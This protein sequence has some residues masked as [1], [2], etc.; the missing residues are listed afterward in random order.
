MDVPP[1]G[2]AATRENSRI[3]TRQRARICAERASA[4]SNIHSA[5]SFVSVSPS[6][7]P[8]EFAD[9]TLGRKVA[10]SRKRVWKIESNNACF[11]NHPHL[12]PSGGEILVSSLRRRCQSEQGQG[13]ETTIDPAI[14]MKTNKTKT[15]FHTPCRIICRGEGGTRVGPDIERNPSPHHSSPRPGCP[16]AGR[17]ELA[18]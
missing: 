4:C 10:D 18:P 9:W 12:A 8:C 1:V 7:S 14:C 3:S 5:H 2:L 6:R 15:E 13:K 11:A 16:L 17:R